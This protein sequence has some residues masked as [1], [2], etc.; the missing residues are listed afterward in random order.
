MKYVID[1]SLAFMWEVP[2]P[3][4][5][6]AEQLRDNYR[7][8]LDELLAPAGIE[9][10]HNVVIVLGNSASSASPFEIGHAVMRDAIYPPSSSAEVDNI[11]VRPPL[12]TPSCAASHGQ[13]SPDPSPTPN[14]IPITRE[15]R[16]SRSRSFAIRL[17]SGSK[18]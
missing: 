10:M 3:L 2:E 8:G 1:A 9:L 15:A 5:A 16:S 11:P 7:L 12:V 18:G 4:S 14:E 13:V 17:M 6:K